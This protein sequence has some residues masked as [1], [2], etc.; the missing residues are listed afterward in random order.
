MNLGKDFSELNFNKV[1]ETDTLLYLFDRDRVSTIFI[2]NKIS[3]TLINKIGIYGDPNTIHKPINFNVNKSNLITLEY[4]NKLHYFSLDGNYINTEKKSY[5]IAS[6]EYF[7]TDFKIFYSAYLPHFSSIK[8]KISFNINI[9][10]GNEVISTLPFIN[11]KS[12]ANLSLLNMYNFFLGED[13]LYFIQSGNNIVYSIK[14]NNQINIQKEFY[15]KFNE[16]D[17]N[18]EIFFRGEYKS[19][20]EFFKR[21][22]VGDFFYASKKFYLFSYIENRENNFVYIDKNAPQKITNVHFE[23]DNIN[24][25]IYPKFL[26]KKKMYAIISKNKYSLDQNK[27]KQNLHF[28]VENKNLK[29]NQNENEYN[30]VLVTYHLKS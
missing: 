3:K 29:D 5:S 21:P 30:Y 16:E 17:Q 7:G 13:K 6:F 23:N 18:P 15:V 27:N 19:K 11:N 25:K 26:H 8:N 1:I 12:I 2:F 10:K 14:N 4:P 22:H 9:E 24:L 28:K 20:V